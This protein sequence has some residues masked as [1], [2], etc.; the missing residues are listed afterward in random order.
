MEWLIVGLG[1]PGERY[2]RTRHN[3]GRDAVEALAARHGIAIDTVRGPAR[4]GTGT[5]F[6]QRVGLVIPTTY[7]N[8]SGRGVSPVARFFQVPAERVL[9]VYDELDLPFGRLRLRAEGGAGGHKGMRSVA[10][11]L[12]SQAFPRLRLGIGRPPPGWDAADYV[13]SRFAPGER[14]EAAF[15]IDRAVVALEDVLGDGLVT[16]MNRHNVSA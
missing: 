8:D 1:N 14:E 2:A 12:A 11:A 15:L 5:I 9:V 7:M 13:L 6:G 10:A 3:V 16:A 4:V